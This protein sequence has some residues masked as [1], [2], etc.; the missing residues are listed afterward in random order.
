[1]VVQPKEGPEGTDMSCKESLPVDGW[2]DQ[3][4]CS[5]PDMLNLD[6]TAFATLMP[7]QRLMAAIIRRAMADLPIS[8]RFFETDNGMFHLCCEALGVD[9]DEVRA[10][11]ARGLKTNAKQ[12][13]RATSTV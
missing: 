10:Q 9:P 11:I 8:R 13:W 6:K 5:M 3:E 12:M 7:E 2:I 4:G 1:M